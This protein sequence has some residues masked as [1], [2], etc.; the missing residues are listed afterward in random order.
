MSRI[1]VVMENNKKQ[2]RKGL[3]AYVTAGCPNYDATL[4]AV[5][6]LEQAGADIIEI[7]MPF[8]DPMA[9]GPVI[10][11]AAVMALR[12][13]ATTNKTR[14][15]IIKIRAK[16]NI[17][18]VVMTYINTILSAGAE[19]FIRSFAE[20]GI[21]GVIVPDMPIEECSL[22]ENI[23][24]KEKVDLIH[25][26]A[27]TTTPE[28]IEEVCKK[29]S[30]FLYCISNTGVTG[31]RKVDYSEIGLII[32]AIRKHTNVPAAVGFGIGD[33]ASALEA[34]R[35]G[36]AVIV[37]SAVMQ[38]VMDEGVGQAAEL[39]SAIRGALDGRE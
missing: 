12:E 18:L 2:E 23:C 16:S 20:A 35:F 31:V 4:Q 9:D 33:T 3:I 38:K 21:D 7:G 22:L 37:G 15:L 8:S 11:K 14:E 5:E 26:A 6:A 34:A 1:S 28:R 32:K 10:Q 19:N 39:I 30:G 29:A 36:D 25:F 17:P 27:P 24:V 13:G